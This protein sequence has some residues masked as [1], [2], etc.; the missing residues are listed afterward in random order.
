MVVEKGFIFDNFADKLQQMN[1]V[2]DN[3]DLLQLVKSGDKSKFYRFSQNLDIE[4]YEARARMAVADYYVAEN[5]SRWMTE[6]LYNALV[7]EQKFIDILSVLA[8]PGLFVENVVKDC[9][10]VLMTAVKKGVNFYSILVKVLQEETRQIDYYKDQPSTI[11]GYDTLKTFDLA[12]QA[13]QGMEALSPYKSFTDAV[14]KFAESQCEKKSSALN[15]GQVKK[16]F[17]AIMVGFDRN[18]LF[19]SAKAWLQYLKLQSVGADVYKKVQEVLSAL[20]KN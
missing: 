14:L 2:L 6:R 19:Y 8:N 3:Q 10:A 17:V 9:K 5:K 18:M 13:L 20:A 4:F 11:F 12:S 7:D 1:V 15:A 16:T